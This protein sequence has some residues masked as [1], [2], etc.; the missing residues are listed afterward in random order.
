VNASFSPGL[1]QEAASRFKPAD[2]ILRPRF[3]GPSRQ[4]RVRIGSADL[5]REEVDKTIARLQ[6]DKAVR[7]PALVVERAAPINIVLVAL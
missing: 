7:F 4:D 5:P 2:I 3:T 6:Q 1:S